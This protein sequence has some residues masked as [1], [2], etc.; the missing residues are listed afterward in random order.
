M[1]PDDSTVDEAAP[2]AAAAP[3]AEAGAAETSDGAED[4]AGEDDEKGRWRRALD[5]YLE[6]KLTE[7]LELVDA[8]LAANP[9]TD[10]RPRLERLR[11]RA[12]DRIETEPEEAAADATSGEDEG[13]ADADAD[14]DADGDEVEGDASDVD[15]G[16]ASDVDEGDA[17]EGERSEADGATE[18]VDEAG[19]DEADAA[20]ATDADETQQAQTPSG[21]V[22]RVE[23]PAPEGKLGKKQRVGGVRRVVRRPPGAPAPAA[24]KAPAAPAAKAAPAKLHPGAA[25]KVGVEKVHA[26][27]ENVAKLVRGL[28]TNLVRIAE[29]YQ[30]VT[31]VSKRK[32][33]AYDQ[34]YEELRTYKDNF[35]LSA[36]KPLFRDILLLYDAVSRAQRRFADGEEQVSRDEAVKALQDIIDEILEV[37]YRRDI[38]RIDEQPDRLDI[39]FQKPVRRIETDDPNEDKTVESVVRDGFRMDGALLRPQEVVVKRCLKEKGQ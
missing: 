35:L 34:L 14:A 30:R 9:E 4:E 5:L 10:L 8:I 15:E 17:S 13:E 22:L 36:Q 20:S 7:S 32:E 1:T 38:E 28:E 3:E 16:D 24:A 12:A 25:T 21:R 6:G 29:A 27:V 26:G 37:L 11:R 33:Q 18:V 2:D 39:D 19:V 23:T 31:Q